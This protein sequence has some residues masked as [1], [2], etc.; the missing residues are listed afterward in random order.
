MFFAVGVERVLNGRRPPFESEKKQK[1]TLNINNLASFFF[2]RSVLNGFFLHT[3]APDGAS[4]FC[5]FQRRA[6]A[7]W[8]NSSFKKRNCLFWLPSALVLFDSS[9]DR[10]RFPSSSPSS[11]TRGRSRGR[12]RRRGEQ[13]RGHDPVRRPRSVRQRRRGD[14]VVFSAVDPRGGRG[15]RGRRPRL[16]VPA[17]PVERVPDGE[18]EPAVALRR[19]ALP[20]G[21]VAAERQAAHV[22]DQLPLK[23]VERRGRRRGRRGRVALPQVGGRGCRRRRCRC[24]RPFR[25]SGEAGALRGRGLFDHSSSRTSSSRSRLAKG[26]ERRGGDRGDGRRGRPRRR[27]CRRQSAAADAA[28][29]SSFLVACSC[30][31]CRDLPRPRPHAGARRLARGLAEGSRRRRGG[32]SSGQRSC[33]GSSRSSET[34]SGSRLGPQG[35]A[36]GFRAVIPAAAAAAEDLHGGRGEGRGA[37]EGVGVGVGVVLFLFFDE[38]RK[39]E[40]KGGRGRQPNVSRRRNCRSCSACSAS[41]AFPQP[42]HRV[43]YSSSGLLPTMFEATGIDLETLFDRRGGAIV[44]KGTGEERGRVGKRKES[45]ENF[46][47][48]RRPRRRQN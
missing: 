18:P 42:H 7:R 20:R 29:G 37:V 31:S 19:A 48:R 9:A 24:C 12:R 1:K 30:P 36:R 45:V 32:G 5:F 33:S 47:C 23:V 10:P 6:G 38:R 4:S 34:R 3:A 28:K 17:E 26:G 14:E 25:R 39:R 21:R 43:G 11:G 27:R 13:H 35:I 2:L 41:R 40:K 46:A 16:S 15:G 44:Q 8:I 22:G